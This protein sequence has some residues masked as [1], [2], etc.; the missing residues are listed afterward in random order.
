MRAWLAVLS[1][2][3]AQAA[4]Q[5]FP[6]KPVRMIVGF[7]TG[8]ATDIAARIVAKSLSENLG[9]QFI[10][11]NR[12][13]AGGILATELLAKAAPDGYTLLLS[14]SGPLVVNPHANSSLPYDV[15]RDLA[16][17]SLAVTFSNV[18]VVHPS[19]PARTLADYLKL[20]AVKPGQMAYA[21]AGIATI[22][23][24][25]GAL[26][27]LR[28]KV[29]LTH[30]AYKG[31]A[32]AMNDL[33]GGQIASM[34]ATMPTALPH[35]KSGKLRALATTSASRSPSLP[36]VPTIAESG[37]PGYDATNWYAFVAPAK[38]PPELLDRL[39]AEIVR[40]LSAPAVRA[41]LLAHG[42]E[43]IPS[44][45]QALARHIEQESAVWAKVVKEAGIKMD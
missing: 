3:A 10:V 15:Q 35:I 36:E 38:T 21:S 22:G 30:V 13:G 16:P 20:A 14:S 9:Q 32:P 45:R 24:L 39:N 33:L 44:S 23:H 1:L 28:A 34:I 27:S 43:A 2:A 8:G 17:L 6:A 7:A 26:L 5:S 41:Q 19:V 31:G 12:A 42:M 11:E 18:L 37:F 4:A 29:E 25:A 40:V